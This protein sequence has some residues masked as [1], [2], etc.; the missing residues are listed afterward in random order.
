MVGY[1]VVGLEYGAYHETNE[2]RQ[3]DNR[4]ENRH[5]LAGLPLL[6]YGAYSFARQRNPIV[7]EISDHPSAGPLPA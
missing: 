7:S 1:P 2:Q 6:R 3:A 4:R 5:A